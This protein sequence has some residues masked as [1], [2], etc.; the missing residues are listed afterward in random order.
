MKKEVFKCGK[1]L[2]PRSKDGKKLP[3]KKETPKAVE[4]AGEEKK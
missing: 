1:R 3:V 4:A 2:D